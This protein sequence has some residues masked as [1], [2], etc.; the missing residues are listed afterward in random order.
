[1][2]GKIPK[3][4]DASRLPVRLHIQRHSSVRKSIEEGEKAIALDPDFT[5]GYQNI[6]ESYLFLNRP[7][8]AKAVLQRSA[9]RKLP[10]KEK[11]KVQFFAAFLNRDR[12]GMDKTAAQIATALPYG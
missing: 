9:Q 12:N 2:D 1:M 6:A 8:Q 4:H 7:E 5:P 10:S 3:G 11:L